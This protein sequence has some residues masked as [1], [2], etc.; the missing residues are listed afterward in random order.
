M[1]TLLIGGG[2]LGKL[3][4]NHFR[5]QGEVDVITRSLTG[6]P[7]FK[8]RGCGHSALDITKKEFEYPM[9]KYD[10][11]IW[12]AAVTV[13]YK[14]RSAEQKLMVNG[15]ANVFR[16]LNREAFRG[17]LI[18]VGCASAIG[19]TSETFPVEPGDTNEPMKA[20][21]FS[22]RG[23]SPENTNPS[24]QQYHLWNEKARSCS[25]P[26]ILL[27]SARIYGPERHPAVRLLQGLRITVADP[28]QWLNFIHIDD[29]F[30]AVIFTYLN[31]HR[32]D[33]LFVSD[34]HPVTLGRLYEHFS[35]KMDLPDVEFH[36][37]ENGR[38]DA[39]SVAVNNSRFLSLG[40][41]LKHLSVLD[42]EY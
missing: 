26:A 25:F 15:T 8:K 33:F 35:N 28:D 34:G 13:D 7:Y 9:E 20:D 4:A 39:R 14:F 23:V 11:V 2:Y 6:N 29:L 19:S 30:D 17:K 37:P 42:A 40:F 24:F 36:P 5:R 10:L 32:S 1:K 21:E 41:R 31:I 16:L 3:L 18:I 22:L 38:D 27:L 12:N